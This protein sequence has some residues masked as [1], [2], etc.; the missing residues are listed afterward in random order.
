MSI[1][2]QYN[3]M[4]LFDGWDVL[5][6]ASHLILKKIFRDIEKII[7]KILFSFQIIFS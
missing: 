6:G 7:L 4:K 2:N 3:N 1:I 5:E